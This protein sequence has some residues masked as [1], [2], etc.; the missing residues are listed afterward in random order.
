MDLDPINIKFI[1]VSDE[2]K[3]ESKAILRFYWKVSNF[4]NII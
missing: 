2:S 3:T 4:I 1:I